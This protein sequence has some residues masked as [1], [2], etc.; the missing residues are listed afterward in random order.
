MAQ[1]PGTTLRAFETSP[2]HVGMIDDSREEAA[3]PPSTATTRFPG[4][5]ALAN[6]A[7]NRASATLCLQRREGV[8]GCAEKQILRLRRLRR[9]R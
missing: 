4:R 8:G 3:W 5:R 6:V 7:G 1:P 2:P 9:L